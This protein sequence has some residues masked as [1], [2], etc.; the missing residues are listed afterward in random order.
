MT[1]TAVDPVMAEIKALRAEIAERQA[2]ITHL[3]RLRSHPTVTP[4]LHYWRH[5]Q[6]YREEA[7]DDEWPA[8]ERAYRLL[9]FQSDDGQLYAEGVMVGGYEYP[10]DDLR[11]MFGEP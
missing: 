11:E 6:E 8:L 7:W 1:E 10:M 9:E 2:R 5:H 3:G 4:I